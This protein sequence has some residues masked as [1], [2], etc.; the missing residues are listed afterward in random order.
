MWENK[1]EL[2]NWIQNGAILY[3]C[4]SKDPMSK[5]VDAKL[6]EIL[7]ERNFETELPALEYL[8]SLEESGRYI[9]DVY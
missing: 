6:V 5:D 7:A 2:L 1:Q 4:G 8:K 3:V 9:K